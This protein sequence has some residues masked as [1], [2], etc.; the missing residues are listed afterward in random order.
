MKQWD[1]FLISIGCILI[2]LSYLMPN[3]L[4]LII[5]G[6]LISGYGVSR[7]RKDKRSSEK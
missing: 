7:L 2:M 6:I 5:S 4:L 3:P 1:L